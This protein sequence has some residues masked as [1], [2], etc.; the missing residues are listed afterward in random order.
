MPGGGTGAAG[1]VGRHA[2]EAFARGAPQVRA[3]VRRK[4]AGPGLRAL[5]AKVAVGWIGDVDTLATVMAGA[6]PGCHLVGG[7]GSSH[8]PEHILGALRPGLA[9]GPGARGGR[10]P[11]PSSP[12][13]P[14]PA[15]KPH[16]P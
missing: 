15:P 6:H 2:V 13:A 7:L 10:I 9:A 5:G 1:L 3:F 8:L 4:E 11:Y 16:P 14:S 12:G